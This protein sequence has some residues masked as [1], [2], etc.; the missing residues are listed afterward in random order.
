MRTAKTLIRQGG[1]PGWSESSL[2]AHA[3]LLVLSWV[4]SYFTDHILN[5]LQELARRFSLSFGLDQ[6]K[7]RDA[8]A[9][10]HRW[11]FRGQ[12]SSKL[13]FGEEKRRVY[14]WKS[15]FTVTHQLSSETQFPTIRRFTS[16]ND[17][18]QYSYPHSNALLHIVTFQTALFCTTR[19]CCQ[20]CK[21]RCQPMKS[22]LRNDVIFPTVIR[23]IYRRKFSTLSIIRH[24]VIFASA[25][26]YSI[27]WCRC[28]N[29]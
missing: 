14:G 22:D 7:N 21:T 28:N 19:K 24:R 23:R 18:F 6:V 3:T 16:P 27:N 29:M 12:L 4:G 25:L 26:E 8:V 5:T 11:I 2:G 17:N 15:C 13:S 1:Y 10:L 20:Q 9:A